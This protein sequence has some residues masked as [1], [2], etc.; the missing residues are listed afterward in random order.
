MDDINIL[1]KYYTVKKLDDDEIKELRLSAIK[2]I[3]SKSLTDDE[4]L[5]VLKSLKSI[6]DDIGQSFIGVN[7][8]TTRWMYNKQHRSQLSYNLQHDGR[9]QKYFNM[10]NKCFTKSTDHYKIPTL[11]EKVLKNLNGL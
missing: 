6:L 11:M 2:F 9:Y 3:E 5:S 7:N 1:I 10:R 4:K 8:I